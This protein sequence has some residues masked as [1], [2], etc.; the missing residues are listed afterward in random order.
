M[1]ARE[2]R[3]HQGISFNL[4]T[5][6]HTW[7]WMLPDRGVI[8]A[9]VSQQEAVREACMAIDLFLGRNAN[10]DS[11]ITC[12]GYHEHWHNML[13]RLAEYVTVA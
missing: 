1:P 3:V 13:E 10:S 7:F 12:E 11:T 8:G 9:A 6:Q 4:W 5:G 2:R